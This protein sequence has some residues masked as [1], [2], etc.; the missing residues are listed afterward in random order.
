MRGAPS[1]AWPTSRASWI[2]PADAG[3]TWAGG[4]IPWRSEDHPRGC[5]EHISTPT[6]TLDVTGSSP[7]M[8]G[9]QSTG[10]GE[11]HNGGIIPADAGST[12]R[13]AG[14]VLGCRDHP[15]GCGEHIDVLWVSADDPGSSPRMRGALGRPGST[16]S[17]SR[18]HPRGCGEHRLSDRQNARHRGSSPRMRGALIRLWT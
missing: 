13:L 10:Q 6:V 3:S 18:D 4:P 5:G 1:S 16:G 14:R 15:R 7:R 11:K 12:H 8:R 2:I 9:A 17:G